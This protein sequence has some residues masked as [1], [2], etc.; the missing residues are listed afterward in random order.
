[1]SVTPALTVSVPV[2]LMREFAGHAVFAE[3]APETLVKTGAAS[4]LIVRG[5][6]VALFR[7]APSASRPAVACAGATTEPQPRRMRTVAEGIPPNVTS[8]FRRT[9]SFAPFTSFA[10]IGMGKFAGHAAGAITFSV[11]PAKADGASATVLYGVCGGMPS[12]EPGSTPAMRSVS[13]RTK[14]ISFE[15]TS[16]FVVLFRL[17]AATSW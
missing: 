6:T 4:M 8:P 14:R 17:S 11:C 1:M 16:A 12:S 10:A 13:R 7:L 2:T 5:E 15:S 3:I 9:V